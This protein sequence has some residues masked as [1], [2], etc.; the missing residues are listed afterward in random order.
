MLEY[1]CECGWT[2]DTPT[3]TLDGDTIC[4]EC[5]AGKL[6]FYVPKSNVEMRQWGEALRAAAV[7]SA[8]RQGLITDEQAAELLR[9]PIK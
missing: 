1:I 7:E 8:R 9:E 2:G 3:S 6:E 4:P 5:G